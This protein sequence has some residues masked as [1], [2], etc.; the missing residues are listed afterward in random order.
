M[1]KEEQQEYSAILPE[2]RWVQGS[3]MHPEGRPTQCLEV[4]T[5]SSRHVERWTI[6]FGAF[7]TNN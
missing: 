1:L 4:H 2:G 5:G 3:V 6:K 7:M